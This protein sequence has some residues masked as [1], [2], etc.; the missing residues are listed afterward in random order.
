MLIDNNG[1]KKGIV[2]L[3]EALKMASNQ[4]LDLVKYLLVA[5][6]QLSVNCQ[7]MVNTYLIRKKV[8][9]HPS[10]KLKEIQQRK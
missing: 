8:T 4:S 2:S 1:E 9:L 3:E 7:I 6:I 10:K 5:L